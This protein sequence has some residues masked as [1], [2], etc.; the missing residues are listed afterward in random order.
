MIEITLVVKKARKKFPEKGGLFM[1]VDNILI[2]K[3]K[4]E[5]QIEL[6]TKQLSKKLPQ[7]NSH[8]IQM[9]LK[10]AEDKS[11]EKLSEQIFDIKKLSK[12]VEILEE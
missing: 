11:L 2:R 9:I 6:L 8:K 7:E 10:D 1:P 12:V 5:G 3:G 4:K